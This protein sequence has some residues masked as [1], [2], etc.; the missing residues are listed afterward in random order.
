MAKGKVV[1]VAHFSSG[2]GSVVCLCRGERSAGNWYNPTV[3][4]SIG[5]HEG[6]NVMFNG[7]KVSPLSSV[8][9]SCVPSSCTAPYEG[10]VWKVRVD[11]PDKYP[12]KSPSIGMCSTLSWRIIKPH[13]LGSTSLFH[14]LPCAHLYLCFFRIHEQDFSSQHWRSVSRFQSFEVSLFL[15]GLCSGSVACWIIGP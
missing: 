12:F 6:W 9:I 14:F 10:G 7:M 15:I 5:V 4:K 2:P 13:L 1:C 8:I 11:L 3:C